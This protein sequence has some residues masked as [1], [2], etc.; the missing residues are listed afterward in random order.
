MYIDKSVPQQALNALIGGTIV[1]LILP[2]NA[3]VAEL[4]KSV[5]RTIPAAASLFKAE[6]ISNLELIKGEG[7]RLAES[8]FRLLQN[9]PDERTS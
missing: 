2:K 7:S 8:V 5:G 4:L 3:S 6:H 1:L 9:Q